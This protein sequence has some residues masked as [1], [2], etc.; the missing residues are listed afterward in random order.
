MQQHN[1]TVANCAAFSYY[2][3]G[4]YFCRD[5]IFKGYTMRLTRFPTRALTITFTIA[6]AASLA[7]CGDGTLGGQFT[8]NGQQGQVTGCT[9][10]SSPRG[11]FREIQNSQGARLR[12]TEV[13]KNNSSDTERLVEAATDRTNVLRP[14]SCKG[15]S[16]VTHSNINGKV[17]GKV[18]L[19]SCSGDGI[20]LTSELT[21]AGC[22][23]AN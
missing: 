8:V 3:L 12:I 14:L 22:T 18:N 10:G 4:V 16:S 9:F 2:D 1:P 7:A 21:Y 5:V 13:R 20:Q 17:R 15:S 19:S 6:A 23:A 11:S